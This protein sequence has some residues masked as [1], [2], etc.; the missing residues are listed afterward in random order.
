MGY[1]NRDI[2]EGI[3]VSETHPL[4]EFAWLAAGLIILVVF[5][6]VALSLAAEHLTR[7]IPFSVEQ[8]AT[9]S[10]S[11][12]YTDEH[13]LSQQQLQVQNYLQTLANALVIHQGL[14]DNMTI[15]I[16]Y[17]D[18][19]TINAFATLGGHIVVFKGLLQ[20]MPHENALSMVMAHEIAHIKH[21]DPIVSLGRGLTVYLALTSIAGVGNNSAFE[22]VLGQTG[23]L[24]MM[25]FSREQESAADRE[26]MLTLKRYYGHLNGAA[27]LF[28]MLE[29]EKDEPNLPSFF[30]T[31][32]LTDKRIKA[33]KG[34]AS[35]FRAEGDTTVKALP[36]FLRQSL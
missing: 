24:T 9:A 1:E 30:N 23:L 20:M 13:P 21:R 8:K 12:R 34:F 6:V 32:P 18:D 31:H 3:N 19:D 7:Y 33:I 25:S 11:K 28:E 29:H 35:S 36:D 10:L 2:P 17:V 22:D 4:K 26:A 5:S 15:K 27:A 16:H 14:D